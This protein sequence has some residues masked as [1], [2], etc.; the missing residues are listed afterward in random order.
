M[1]DIKAE[2]EFEAIEELEEKIAPALASNHNE[3]LVRDL[4]VEL[5]AIF[6]QIVEEL[7]IRITPMLASNHNET[8]V[9]D[10]ED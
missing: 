10:L 2:L 5:E 3:T 4:T 6:E 8:L 7:E 1:D 9:V